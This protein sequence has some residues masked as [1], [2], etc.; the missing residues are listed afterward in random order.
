[1]IKNFYRFIFVI[2]SP[3]IIISLCSWGFY[4]HE[5]ATQLAVYQLPKN[6]QEFFFSNIDSLTAHSIRPDKRRYTDKAENPKHFIDLEAYSDNAFSEMPRNWQQAIKK[7]SLDTLK[8]YGF[9]PYQVLIEYDSL[10]N[11]FKQK[12]AERIIFYA[13][14][15]AHYIEDANVPLHTAINYDGQLTNQK[16]LH[17]L[18]ESTIPQLELNTYNLHTNHKAKYITDKSAAIWNAVKQAHDLLPEVFAKER[19]VAKNFPGNSKYVERKYHGRKTNVYSNK[20]AKQYAAALGASINNRLIYSASMVSDF[21]Y[22]AWVDAGKPNLKN[23]YHFRRK[24]KKKLCRELKS[25]KG[26]RLLQDGL[27]RAKKEY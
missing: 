18:W 26:N 22:S 20:F 11:A 10:V 25:D 1:M 27:L 23:L 17:A 21:W 13:D 5:T 3:I 15:L 8:K 2:N 12:N 6:L 16:G 7:Y 9:L 19:E 14:D 4:V 24:N